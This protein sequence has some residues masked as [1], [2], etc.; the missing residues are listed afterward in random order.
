MPKVATHTPTPWKLDEVWMLLKGPDGEE[1]AA[2][3]SAEPMHGKRP[4]RFIANMNAAHIVHCVNLHDELILSLKEL[5]EA[6]TFISACQHAGNTLLITPQK[7]SDLYHAI[8]TANAALFEA[9]K[10]GA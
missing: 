8:N 9:K 3:H 10:G 7:W 6:A 4:D 2:L 5:A 1:I